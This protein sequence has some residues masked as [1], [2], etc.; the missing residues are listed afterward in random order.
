[1][2]RNYELYISEIKDKILS[3]EEELRLI[4]V[5]QERQAGW[6]E[7]MDS[8]IKSNLMYVV[9]V[10]FEFSK[11]PNKVS[12]LIS[13]G[14]IALLDS[15]NK[16]N[17]EKGVKL[18]SYATYEIRGRMTRASVGDTRLSYLEIPE[19]T[20]VVINKISK[21]IEEY[22][23]K[24]DYAPSS[25]EIAKHFDIK[26]HSATT[27]VETLGF[28]NFSLDQAIGEE[29]DQELSSVIEDEQT[30]RPDQALDF[31]QKSSIIKKIIDS[32]PARD[33][34]IVNKRFGFD[35]DEP[36]DLASIGRDLNLT[37]ERIRQIEFS[38]IKKIRG[39]IEK[40]NLV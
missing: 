3:Q 37:R 23:D 22:K 25:N 8:V 35:G 38:A 13:E 9:K 7:A 33:K 1:M 32:W 28:K 6:E 19:R 40:L 17:P 10:A 29:A 12:D 21:F 24:H 5:Y 31:K 14:N 16:F 36:Q 30:D 4:K 2:N 15:L 18:I 11:D 20:R 26:E 34:Y 27:F 39:E